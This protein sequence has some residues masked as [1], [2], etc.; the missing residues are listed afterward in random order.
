MTIPLAE[1]G[2]KKNNNVNKKESEARPRVAA[3]QLEE[4]LEEALEER[5]LPDRRLAPD[6]AATAE[7]RRSEVPRRSKDR[8]EDAT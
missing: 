8:N 2:K 3:E 5:V 1:A 6:E 4:A 7:D